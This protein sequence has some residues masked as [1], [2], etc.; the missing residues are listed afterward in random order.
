MTLFAQLRIHRFEDIRHLFVYFM[1]RKKERKKKKER[2]NIGE[3][4]EEGACNQRRFST[5][6]HRYIH[7]KSETGINHS[8]GGLRVGKLQLKVEDVVGAG[9]PKLGLD[10]GHEQRRVSGRR[11]RAIL[12]LLVLLLRRRARPWA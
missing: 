6:P 8:R 12:L 5:T 11:R 7:K 3:R 1:G 9:E 4:S 2:K 10:D